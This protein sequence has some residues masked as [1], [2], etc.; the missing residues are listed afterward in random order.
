[1][2]ETWLMYMLIANWA[3]M[4]MLIFNSCDFEK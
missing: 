3:L 4:L 2:M 1:M